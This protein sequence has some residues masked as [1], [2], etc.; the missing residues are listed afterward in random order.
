MATASRRTALKG[1]FGASALGATLLAQS[2][3]AQTP[4][5]AAAGPAGEP[6]RD[7]IDPKTGHRIVRVSSEPGSLG[8]YFYRPVY[9][10]LGDLMGI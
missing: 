1:L 8:L 5:P 3:A 2:T 7:W 6:P 4:Q 9:T 10:P